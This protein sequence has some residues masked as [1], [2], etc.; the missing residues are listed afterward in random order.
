[1]K[2]GTALRTIDKKE[3][4]VLQ[5]HADRG[6]NAARSLIDGGAISREG[7]PDETKSALLRDPAMK[8]K[9]DTDPA[10]RAGFDGLVWQHQH[11]SKASYDETVS[12]LEA[13]DARYAQHSIS[14]RG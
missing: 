9:Y 4:A 8:A 7:A 3:A 2:M 13:R 5:L 12:R 11:D 10:F 14:F 1:M 6:M